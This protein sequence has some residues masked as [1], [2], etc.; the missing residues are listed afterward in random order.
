M[1]PK[2][3]R[4][5]LRNIDA[6]VLC[7]GQ[8]TRLRSVLGDTQKVVA[9]IGSRTL[10]DV[11][12]AN[13]SSQGFARLILCVGHLK[14]QI[15]DKYRTLPNI[16]FSEEN[17][18]LGTGG[19]V[20]NAEKLITSDDFFVMNGDSIFN[21]LDASEFYDFHKKHGALVSLA[22]A[23]PRED[24][25]FGG[26]VLAKSNKI[27]AFTEKNELDETKF[28]SGGVYFMK[29][30]AL[31]LMPEKPFSLEND[32]FPKLTNGSLYGFFSPGEVLDIGTPERYERAKTILS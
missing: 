21:G 7:G 26:V 18:P 17:A 23:E 2:N 9:P 20:K 8:G 1:N 24:K 15:I 14:K 27:T 6:V 10:L 11:L 3:T 30:D 32:F 29:N 12:M 4:N 5:D 31:R 13:L 28:M 22:L 16:V 25:D 19:A